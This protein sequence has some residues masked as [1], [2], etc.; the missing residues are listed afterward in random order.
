MSQPIIAPSIIAADFSRLEEQV[1]AAEEGGAD[2]LHLDIMDGHF[3][4]NITFGPIV[5]EATRR[6]T[7]LPLDIHLMIDAPERY[8]EDFRRAGADRITVHQ[9]ACCHLNRTIYQI[10]ELG[11]EA[12]VALNPST[13]VSF[14]KEILG[15]IDLVLIMSVNPGFGGQAFIPGSLHKIVELKGMLRDVDRKV[16]IE[17][18]GGIEP[19]NAGQVVKAGAD[20]LVAGTSVFGQQDIPLAIR[21]LR[22][23][24]TR[25]G[26]KE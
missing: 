5:V 21:K 1:R 12:G 13:P 23:S 26:A 20:V 15:E 19:S 18:D 24:A 2:W 25:T 8:V 17:V 9:E 6:S 7:T 3:V 11:A 16:L 22:E 14:L 10:K 4:P